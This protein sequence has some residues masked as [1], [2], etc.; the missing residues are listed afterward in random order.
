MVFNGLQVA[1]EFGFFDIPHALELGEGLF[2]QGTAS[3]V[4]RNPG[5]NGKGDD[6]H[7]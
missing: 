6:T 1:Q 2:G 7:A 4:Q 5:E 3:L